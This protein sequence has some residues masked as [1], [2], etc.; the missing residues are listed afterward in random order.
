MDSI[1]NISHSSLS[2]GKHTHTMP[3]TIYQNVTKPSFLHISTFLC[4]DYAKQPI[5]TLTEELHR[6]EQY[7]AL[8]LS[9]G[10]PNQSENTEEQRQDEWMLL[11]QL[12]PTFTATEPVSENVDWE[13]GARQ[14]PQPLLLSCLNWMK[15]MRAETDDSTYRR[16]CTPVDINC[17]NQQQMT[18]YQIVSTHC[19]TN[20]Q[21]PLH[22]LI[23]GTADTGKSFLIQAISQLL[24]NK[25]LLTATTGIAAFNI[26]GITLHSA[27]HIVQKHNCNDLRGQALAMLQ[28]KLRDIKYSI[29][30]EV[31]MLGQNMMAW[32]DKR[33][34][35][36]TTHLDI[37]FGGISVILIGD[38][39]QLPP[40]GDRPLFAP[41]GKGSHG[42]TMYLLFTKVVI[43]NQVIRQN[44]TNI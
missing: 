25:C 18:A 38:F 29:V 19:T 9:T 21:Q 36:A 27:L 7:E 5:A 32:V 44:G 16:Q 3:G 40:V 14:L 12:Q 20:D 11:C 42:H 10:D 23:L 33:L 30:D 2:H 34:H 24:Q 1:A 41:E 43:L 39:A 26:G 15:P 13:E 6:A 35:Q 22:M 37:P 4:T 8:H 28:H 31:S 17:L